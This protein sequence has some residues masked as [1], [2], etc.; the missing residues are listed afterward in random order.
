MADT[1]EKQKKERDEWPALLPCQQ[2][3]CK[4]PSTV[5]TVNDCKLTRLLGRLTTMT[6][7]LSDMPRKGGQIPFPSRTLFD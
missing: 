7:L 2:P 6:V 3:C 4:R 1:A 5:D